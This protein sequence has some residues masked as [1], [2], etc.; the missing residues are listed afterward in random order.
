[1]SM[2][3][4]TKPCLTKR[5]LMGALRPKALRR[6]AG[7]V[8]QAAETAELLEDRRLLAGNIAITDLT[9]TDLAGTRIDRLVADQPA[10]ANV[11]W[12]VSGSPGSH[13]I[14][15]TV[16]GQ[17]Q[18]YRANSWRIGDLNAFRVLFTPQVGTNTISGSLV[19]AA[20]G[21]TNR[22]D[23]S[24]S[25]ALTAS[26]PNRPPV[27]TPIPNRQT[28]ALDLFEQPINVT[29]P[30]GNPLRVTPQSLPEGASVDASGFR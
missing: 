27:T 18:T 13:E 1:M 3:Q 21:D 7:P 23:N 14:A 25:L 16:N 17:T 10:Y 6:K 11:R 15:L 8:P 22:L 2:S 19:S 5:S 4:F 29:D 12:S 28:M 24:R 26:N 9:V 20:N 30:D